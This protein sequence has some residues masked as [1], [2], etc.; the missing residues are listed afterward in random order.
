MQIGEILGYRQD[1]DQL[2]PLRRLKVYPPWKFHPA[3]GAQIFLPE[4]H[5]A[6]QGNDG[7]NVEPV[8]AIQQLLVV[9]KTDQEHASNA[10]GDPVDL[11]DMGPG[12][13]AVHGGAANLH[14]AKPADHQDK[15]EEQPVEITEW[16]I[17]GHEL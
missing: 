1:Q 4:Q 17:A 11:P 13:L 14:H 10:T 5:H 2:Y 6:H 7:S 16:D 3:A 15:D 9:H 8:H 12:E